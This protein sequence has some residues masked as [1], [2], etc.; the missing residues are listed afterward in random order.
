MPA[1]NA[2][3]DTDRPAETA[4]TIPELLHILHANSLKVAALLDSDSAGENAARK[5]TLVHTLGNKNILRTAE[6][7]PGSISQPEIEDLL[8]DTLV[9]I[10]KTEF[11]WDITDAATSQPNRPI[12]KIFR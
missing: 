4:D 12:A 9:S 1:A 8:R 2:R 7:C 6:V 11:G 10:A 3:P 5:D